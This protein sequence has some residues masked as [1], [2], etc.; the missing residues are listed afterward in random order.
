M[1]LTTSGLRTRSVASEERPNIP[2]EY[3]TSAPRA[4]AAIDL[5]AATCRTPGGSERETQWTGY[6]SR[7]G[8]EAAVI[9]AST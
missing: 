1:S 8:G 6:A 4:P 3:T 2:V 5:S 7:A 9:T